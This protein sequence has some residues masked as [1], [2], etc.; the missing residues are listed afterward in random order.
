MNFHHTIIEYSRN[1]DKRYFD[2]DQ[3]GDKYY[4]IYRIEKKT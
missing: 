3:I 1:S 4:I 2:S